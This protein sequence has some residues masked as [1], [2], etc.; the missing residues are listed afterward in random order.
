[1]VAVDRQT[2][3]ADLAI[4]GWVPCMNT[5]TGRAGIYHD[6]LGVGFSVRN[7]DHVVA[8]GKAGDSRVKRWDRDH[9]RQSYMPCEWDEVTDWHLDTIEK[10]LAET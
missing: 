4:H 7:D 6:Q 10:R 9:F 3:I 2:R 5:G 8:A 1:M